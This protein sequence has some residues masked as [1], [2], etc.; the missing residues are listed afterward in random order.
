MNGKQSKAQQPGAGHDFRNLWAAVDKIMQKQVEERREL[1]DKLRERDGRLDE[2]ANVVEELRANNKALSDSLEKQHDASTQSAERLQGL[3]DGVAAQAGEVGGTASKA[4]QDARAAIEEQIASLANRAGAVEE[5]LE[6]TNDSVRLISREHGELQGNVVQAV[7][8]LEAVRRNVD[9][10]LEQSA[11]VAELRSRVTEIDGGL[12][13]AH[14][15]AETTSEE[16]QGLSSSVDT[17]SARVASVAEDAGRALEQSTGVE[18]IDSVVGNLESNVRELREELGAQVD[19]LGTQVQNFTNEATSRTEAVNERVTAICETQ[20]ETRNIVDGVSPELER[21]QNRISRTEARVVQLPKGLM[22]NGDGDLIGINGE[23]ET[24]RIGHVKGGDGLDGVSVT[25][26]QIL[27]G[28]LKISMSNGA[29]V[30]AGSI[31]I[32]QKQTFGENEVRARVRSL[33]AQG[34]SMSAIS[35]ELDIS[36]RQVRKYIREQDPA[37]QGGGRS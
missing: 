28:E 6:R 2:F 10:A 30:S 17:L 21:L 7:E 15:L 5:Q 3:I 32:E 11:P 25:G 12:G 14:A 9:Q 33:H 26:A 13:R 20:S 18:R 1:E 37:I 23:G 35:R 34:K 4:L 31:R 36:S 24:Q 27:D 8:T 22:I 16:L 29:V 19:E